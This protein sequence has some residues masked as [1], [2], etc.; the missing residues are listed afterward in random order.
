[1]KCKL[2]L[3]DLKY[4]VRVMESNKL[5]EY[6]VEIEEWGDELPARITLLD[7]E[8]FLLSAD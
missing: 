7:E 4:A 1:M 2:N 6:D 3:D 8:G 5:T